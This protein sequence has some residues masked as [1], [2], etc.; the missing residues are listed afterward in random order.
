MWKSSLSDTEALAVDAL[1]ARAA[2]MDGSDPLNEDARLTRSHGARH[3]LADVDGE[4]VGY[5]H[6]SL[7]F[8]TAQVVVD[9]AHRRQGVGSAL[10]GQLAATA[11]VRLWAFGDSPAARGF[12]ASLGLVAGRAL[13]VMAKDLRPAQATP[14][15]SAPGRPQ[16]SAQDSS[17]GRPQGSGEPYPGRGITLRGFEPSDAG[18]LLAVNAAAFAHHLEQG[19]LDLA[20]LNSRLDEAWFD[21]DGLILAFDGDRLLGFHWTKRHDEDTGE[22]YVLGVHPDAQGRGVGR[23]LLTAGLA[24]LAERGCRKVIL[25]VDS[26]DQVAVELYEST[27]FEIAHRD[28][29]YV[30]VQEL[31]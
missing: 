17:P 21:P 18:Q 24:Y 22:V 15:D 28:V 27:G 2:A 29:C 14:Q 10:V 26:A 23:R 11:A 7:E 19:A 30:P 8:A 4:L 31:P 1:A 6:H 13:L 9:P 20:G 12:A 16:G 5:L 3:L 25:Y